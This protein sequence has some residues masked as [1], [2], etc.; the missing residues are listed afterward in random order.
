M[1]HHGPQKSMK[2]QQ[3]QIFNDMIYSDIF[4]VYTAIYLS[5]AQLNMIN[6]M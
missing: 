4:N 3:T 2:S 1:Y 6:V 5:T